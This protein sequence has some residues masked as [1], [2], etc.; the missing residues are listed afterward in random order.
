MLPHELA[1]QLNHA[2]FKYNSESLR[3]YN[4]IRLFRYQQRHYS[5]IIDSSA[6]EKYFDTLKIPEAAQAKDVLDYRGQT[7]LMNLPLAKTQA[8]RALAEELS[9]IIMPVEFTHPKIMFGEDKELNVMYNY[10]SNV[11][12]EDLYIMCPINYY[13]HYRHIA[14]KSEKELFAPTRFQNIFETLEI[15]RTTLSF[16]IDKIDE[17]S[18]EVAMM[19]NKINA[20]A[21]KVNLLENRVDIVENIQRE[22]RE[23]QL[24]AAQSN[25]SIED[26]F[27][28]QN[29]DPML[30]SIPRGK[31]INSYDGSSSIY[32]VWGEDLPDIVV[33]NKNLKVYKEN[34]MCNPNQAFKY[35]F[36]DK[37]EVAPIVRLKY[38][39]DF[40][41]NIKKEGFENKLKKLTKQR[42]EAEEAFGWSLS[43]IEP[44]Y[45]AFGILDEL[46]KTVRTDIS[47]YGFRIKD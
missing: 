22:Q 47:T 20:L 5:Y 17:N 7:L 44:T 14:S 25:S 40:I 31:N 37:L 42:R 43:N 29:I 23:Q 41:N 30:I 8:I 26:T 45:I 46:Y 32:M 38:T 11:V 19:D 39:E 1:Y 21:D 3:Q 34:K 24:K 18:R 4:D 36:R 6:I 35:V 28:Y 9:M 10:Y 2:H 12:E 33:A 13:N 27:R 16:M 15:T